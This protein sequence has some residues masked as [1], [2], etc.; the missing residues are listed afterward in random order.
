M[1]GA[2]GAL[3]WFARSA[4]ALPLKRAVL[5][6]VGPRTVQRVAGKG[7]AGV[8]PGPPPCSVT[9]LCRSATEA[10]RRQGWRRAVHSAA[11]ATPAGLQASSPLTESGVGLAGV[12]APGVWRPLQVALRARD[13]LWTYLEL[14]KY[15]L[16][17]LVVFSTCA[18]YIVR[19]NLGSEATAAGGDPGR[20]AGI[21]HGRHAFDAYRFV[22]T[23][24]G[25]FLCAAAANMMNQVIECGN[26]ARMR[27]TARRPLPSGRIGVTHAMGVA[28]LC[29][30]AGVALLL[31]KVDETTA[32]LGL[33]NVLLYVSVYTPLKTL[34][35]LN[36]WV[37][38][39]V[40]AIPPL[41]GWTAASG[42]HLRTGSED[43][44]GAWM[45]AA[46]LF[47]WQI[48]HFHA[49]AMLCQADYAA[50][51]YR[52]LA[53]VNPVWNA[54][55][56]W[57]TSAALLPVG[58]GMAATGVTSPWF[59]YENS[60]LALWLLLGATWLLRRP[61]DVTVARRL[62]RASITY[63]PVVLVLLVLHSGQRPTLR[64]E[65]SVHSASGERDRARR[66]MRPA[67]G[68]S[69]TV[70]EPARPVPPL[71]TLPEADEWSIAHET[72]ILQA[73]FA[74]PFPFLPA[75]E[76]VLLPWDARRR[77]G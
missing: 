50:G 16:T 34:T 26:D 11:E 57:L 52:M 43:E 56:A 6:R 60:A 36:T 12:T 3:R 9:A 4:A 67:A 23:T 65:A 69:E 71:T 45:L 13:L 33:G 14:V 74:A 48:P 51:G 37:G 15:R 76:P 40:G 5:I 44:R 73:A 2:L 21:S 72:H 77:S 58:I 29:G 19:S 70:A 54:R 1:T 32:T 20:S 61:T 68:S 17:A 41:M 53:Q 66:W 8:L 30:I 38:A 47:L 75:P 7:L 64:E 18:G 25:T 39:I 27:R 28:M 49:L 63:L 46:L 55:W 62:F 10:G 42:G 24:A 59:A 31:S 35:P 22:F